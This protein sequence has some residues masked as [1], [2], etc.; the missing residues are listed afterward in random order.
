MTIRM[1][2]EARKHGT[3]RICE[4]MKGNRLTMERSKAIFA[5][6]DKAT[7]TAMSAVSLEL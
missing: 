4:I 2:E 6:R 5:T 7:E 3:V 1:I